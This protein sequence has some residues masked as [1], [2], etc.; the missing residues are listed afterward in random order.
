MSAPFKTYELADGTFVSVDLGQHAPPNS[1]LRQWEISEEAYNELY[2]HS[3]PAIYPDDSL[4]VN[5]D[6]FPPD[7]EP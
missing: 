5:E 7:P 6:T 2:A 3:I 1:H 4:G